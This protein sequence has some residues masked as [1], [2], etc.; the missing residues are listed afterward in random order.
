MHLKLAQV[1]KIVHGLCYFPENIFTLQPPYS[2]RLSRSDTL[3]CP[4]AR[5]NYYFHSFVPSSIRSWNLLDEDQVASNSLQSFKIIQILGDVVSALFGSCLLC[6][7]NRR[8]VFILLCILCIPV[9][10]KVL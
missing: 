4:F 8:L 7:Y 9:L 6:V 1:F 2:S 3:L 5:T 10:H